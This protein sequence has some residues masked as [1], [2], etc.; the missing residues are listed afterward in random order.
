MAGTAPGYCFQGEN[1][2]NFRGHTSRVVTARVEA[3]LLKAKRPL[4]TASP[5]ENGSRRSRQKVY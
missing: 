5:N 1:L 3:Y 4:V 2:L